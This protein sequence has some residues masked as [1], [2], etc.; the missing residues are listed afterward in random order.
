[1]DMQRVRSYAAQYLPYSIATESGT[2]EPFEFLRQS[3]NFYATCIRVLGRY[4]RQVNR[5]SMGR[6]RA[7][8]LMK[9]SVVGR[10]V[11]AARMENH[12]ILAK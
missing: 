12:L 10:C 8:L 3:V 7:A 5:K 4:C 2:P 9:D 11:N 6:K 1:M